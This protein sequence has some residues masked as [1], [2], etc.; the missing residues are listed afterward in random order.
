M[1]TPRATRPRSSDTE[2]YLQALSMRSAL[3]FFRD[4]YRDSVA[5]DRVAGIDIGDTD[6]NL[7]EWGS[8]QYLEEI[9][10]GFPA[11]HVWWHQSLS[12]K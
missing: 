8:Q 4:L 5:H 3:E 12:G 1:A 6:E 2:D 11:S 10:P 9:P 7:K